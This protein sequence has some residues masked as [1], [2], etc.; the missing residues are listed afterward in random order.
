MTES[1]MTEAASEMTGTEM[2]ES[3]MTESEMTVA[4]SEMTGTDLA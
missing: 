1:E 2:A 3:E 4:A